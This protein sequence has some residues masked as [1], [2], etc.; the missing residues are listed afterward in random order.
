MVCTIM[1]P[2]DR[3]ITCARSTPIASST[4][5]P[6]A[7]MSLRC[8]PRP[9]SPVRSAVEL[10]RQPDVAVVE[11][12]DLQARGDEH[13]APVLVVVDALAPQAVDQQQGRVR[14]ITERLVVDLAVAVEGR[15]HAATVS[16]R[17]RGQR[18]SPCGVSRGTQVGVKHSTTRVW[19][20]SRHPGGR[21][22][23]HRA[24]SSRAHFS[25]VTVTVRS[26]V[27]RT[28]VSVNVSLVPERVVQCLDRYEGSVA[29]GD[30]QIPFGDARLVGWAFGLDTADEQTRHAAVGRPTPEAS[31]R[32]LAVPVRCRDEDA[33]PT[34]PRPD[35]R[36]SS[37][38]QRR[39]AGRRRSRGRCGGC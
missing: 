36:S 26:S 7:A 17:F 16:E 2:I 24:G 4:A 38:V 14:R 19:S 12:R 23:L 8:M 22:T 28:T 11:A 30:Q 32:P 9:R 29:G 27:P 13:R 39:S 20:V 34:C 18:G 6:S 31:L 10:G 33:R 5:M 1:P 21:E 35:L 25:N 3:P 37:A 15:G